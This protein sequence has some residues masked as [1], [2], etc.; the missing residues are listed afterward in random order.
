MNPSLRFAL[1]VTFGFLVLLGI[2][3]GLLV[4]DVTKN[5][6]P[7]PIQPYRYLIQ[8][9]AVLIPEIESGFCEDEII[10]AVRWTVENRSHRIPWV[11]MDRVVIHQLGIVSDY[12][13]QTLRVEAATWEEI[14]NWIEE[15]AV[16]GGCPVT[17]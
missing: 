5:P 1:S 15:A 17:E 8:S 14:E 2:G 13:S 16:M 3:T 7:Q 12:V 11:D 9:S 4:S 10:Q 6:D